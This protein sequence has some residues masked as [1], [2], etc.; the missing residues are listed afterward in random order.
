M[1]S[2]RNA[3][4]RSSILT[5]QE[6]AAI[7]KVPRKTVVSLCA[8]GLLPGARKVGRQW[9]I[10]RWALDEM[11]PQPTHQPEVSHACVSSRPKPVECGSGGRASDR[12]G[13][14]TGPR[15]RPRASRPESASKSR[16]Q[17]LQNSASFQEVPDLFLLARIL[18]HSDARVTKLYSHLLPEHPARARNAVRFAAPAVRM[19]AR[20]KAANRWRLA[21]V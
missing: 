10:P 9:R 15:T 21:D 18:G 3:M 5:P 4:R 6:T 14:S 11:F 1:E 17:T 16:R 8:R 12:I 20:Q 19:S 2:S 13:S 7:L